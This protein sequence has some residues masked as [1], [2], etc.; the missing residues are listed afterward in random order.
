MIGRRKKLRLILLQ[1]FI[2]LSF[3]V[4]PVRILIEE[5]NTGKKFFSL[6]ET[7]KEYNLKGKL[8]SHGNWLASLYISFYTRS[9]Y[10]GECRSSDIVGISDEL[11]EK[12]ID[13]YLVWRVGPRGEQLRNNILINYPEITKG[14][15][16]D[17]LIYKIR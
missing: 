3:V 13:Y 1:T 11:I 14:K 5:K 12:G 8:A 17:L 9:Q 4:S 10:Y 15:V 7:L 16:N 2:I 6:N